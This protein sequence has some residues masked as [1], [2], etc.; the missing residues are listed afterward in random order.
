MLTVLTIF[1]K[2]QKTFDYLYDQFD[3]QL[4]RRCNFLFLLAGFASELKLLFTEVEVQHMYFTFK[5]FAVLFSV[6]LGFVLYKF[7]IAP[8]L[9]IIGKALKG[10]AE[11]IDIRVVLAYSL[12]PQLLTVPMVLYLGFNDLYG[13]IDGLA[14]GIVNAVNIST[15]LLSLNVLIRGLYQYNQYSWLKAAINGS[16][17]WF[18]GLIYLAY[19]ISLFF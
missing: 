18:I 13:Q 4:N 16:P 10:N 15:G 11:L 17:F 1:I 6:M 12:I 9:F 19:Q 5:F 8:F 14:L 3:H 7:L 2:P